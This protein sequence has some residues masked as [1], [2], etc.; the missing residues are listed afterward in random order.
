MSI[1]RFI[2]VCK[3]FRVDLKADK[4]VTDKTKFEGKLKKQGG[5]EKI[6]K[7]NI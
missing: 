2:S 6:L 4:G 5:F 7:E 1:Q 3:T